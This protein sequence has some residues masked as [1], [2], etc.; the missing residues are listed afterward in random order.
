[1]ISNI[2]ICVVCSYTKNIPSSGLW[3]KGSWITGGAG[4]IDYWVV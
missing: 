1:M 2:E 3:T 4:L